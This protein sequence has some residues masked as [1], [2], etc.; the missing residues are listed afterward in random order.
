MQQRIFYNHGPIDSFREGLERR[1]FGVCNLSL[2]HQLESWA[3]VTSKRARNATSVSISG[4]LRTAS[5]I[6]SF[7]I[8]PDVIFKV[9]RSYFRVKFLNFANFCPFLSLNGSQKGY[10]N[11]FEIDI[12]LMVREDDDFRS[13]IFNSI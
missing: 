2:K 7:S 5:S 4:F 10:R 1:D 11:K 9:K 12:G 8:A 3:R 13:I 6:V